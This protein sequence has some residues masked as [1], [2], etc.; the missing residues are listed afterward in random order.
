MPLLFFKYILQQIYTLYRN[1]S[2]CPV[3]NKLKL[4]VAKHFSCAVDHENK[5][6]LYIFLTYTNFVEAMNYGELVE[7][8]FRDVPVSISNIICLAKAYP[9][10]KSI[11]YLGFSLNPAVP[12][13]TLKLSA[14]GHKYLTIMIEK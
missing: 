4:N 11:L 5:N 9:P 12:A 7:D 13:H 2:L 10:P 14:T 6:T 3:F 8:K 1:S